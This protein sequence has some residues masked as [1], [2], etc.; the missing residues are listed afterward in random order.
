MKKVLAVYFIFLLAARG[1]MNNES[2]ISKVY[3]EFNAAYSARNVKALIG[4]MSDLDTTQAWSFGAGLGPTDSDSL[5]IMVAKVMLEAFL[6]R[7]GNLTGISE[8]DISQFSANELKWTNAIRTD[9]VKTQEVVS[10]LNSHKPAER[11]I[12]LLKCAEHPVDESVVVSNIM[13]IAMND[14][15]FQI[16]RAPATNS[17]QKPL[18]PGKTSTKF[19]FPLRDLACKIL[20]KNSTNIS[21]ENDK[22]VSD[23]IGILAKMWETHPGRR[24]AIIEAISLL[25]ADSPEVCKLRAMSGAATPTSLHYHFLSE[26]TIPESASGPGN[27][28]R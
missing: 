27:G 14:D 15:F 11:F 2:T 17:G 8:Q 19:S 28:N 6:D 10:L 13:N 4:L 12:G 25:D 5:Q 16:I 18:P 3:F 23:G 7:L 21:I 22:L 26:I 1:E 9:S 24:Q 20:A